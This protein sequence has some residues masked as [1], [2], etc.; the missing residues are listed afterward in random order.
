MGAVLVYLSNITLAMSSLTIENATPSMIRSYLI[1]NMSKMG[2]NINIENLTDDSITFDLTRTKIK[3][4]AALFVMDAENKITLTFTPSEK[5]TLLT[6]NA[7]G[8]AH[9]V[10]GHEIVAPT[11]SPQ[12][13]MYFLESIKINFDGGYLYGFVLS[14]QKKDGGFPLLSV[15]PNSPLDKAGLKVGDVITKVNG[16]SL[17]YDKRNKL[18]NFQTTI[19]E[20]RALTFTV[21]YG[22]TEKDIV[23]TSV[24]FDPEKK[25]YIYTD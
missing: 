20:P 14:E 8:R 7:V 25:Q 24:F 9:T 23:V 6:Y 1:E 21:K 19:Y 11:S 3:G 12:S 2:E 10:D 13:E 5:G 17:K 4:L 16:I 22:K 15:A 18:H